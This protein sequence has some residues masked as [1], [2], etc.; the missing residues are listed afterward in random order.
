MSNPDTEERVRPSSS[1]SV[2][3]RGNVRPT[4]PTGLR[5]AVYPGVVSAA[6]EGQV[7]PAELLGQMYPQQAKKELGQPV[8]TLEGIVKHYKMKGRDDTVKALTDVT[9]ADRSGCFG[10]VR[11]G[12]FLMIRG[13]SG[14]GKTTLLNLIGTLDKPTAGTINIL[15]DEVTDKSTDA[16]LAKLRLSK[17]GFVFQTFNLISTMSAI[18][19][20]ELPMILAGSLPKK[21]VRHRAKVLLRT[22]GLRDR[23]A[24]LPSEL[25]GGEQQR[26]TIARALANNPTILLLDEPTGDLDTANTVEIMDLLLKINLEARCTCV[27]VT[28][29]KDV[30]CYADRILYVQDGVFKKQVFNSSQSRLHLPYYL[31]HLAA[32]ANDSVPVSTRPCSAVSCQA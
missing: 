15:G 22:V 5:G 21:E 20:I 3:S 10:P 2:S 4:S 31:A 27:M 16:F 26:V 8:I 30:E 1:S 24:H 28:H 18:E 7:V 29:N 14:G 6:V 11:A 9:L 19:N 13:P 23:G 32:A 17:I 12:E 25:S